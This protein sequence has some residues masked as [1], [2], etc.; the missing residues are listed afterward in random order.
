MR[1]PVLFAVLII[2]LSCELCAQTVIKGVV[3]D[4]S[5]QSIPYAA[6]YLSK[7]TIGTMTNK[8]GAYTLTIPQNG[9]YELTASFIGYKSFSK[10]I[11]AEGKNLTIH[12]KL[13]ENS[14]LL[15]EITVQSKDRN[16][17]TNYALF[18]KLFLGETVNA[19]NCR[20]LNPEDLYLY[21]EV[22]TNRL[23]GHSLKSLRIENRSLGYTIVYDLADFVY[24]EKSGLLKFTGS[25]YFIPLEGN[26]KYT[27]R[28][29]RN[30]LSAYYGSR[31]HFL[32]SLYQDSLQHEN[33]LIYQCELDPS[34]KDTVKIIPIREDSL[35]MSRDEKSMI[36]FSSKPIFVSYL[37]THAE[38]YSGLFGF[39]PQR[40]KT[41]L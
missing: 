17:E 25:N 39:Q 24:D 8:E 13:A 12:I 5:N 16:R 2:I 35:R 3:T 7:T 37:D 40:Y 30:R 27:K 1:L 38:L 26:A 9:E 20:I 29:S 6:V 31:L 21:R 23:K 15:D 14:I 10:I 4:A 11:S 33:F 28:W 19:L 18:N 41:T 36:L 22:N 32:R 34:G